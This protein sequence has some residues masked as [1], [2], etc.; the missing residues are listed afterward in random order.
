[1]VY[2]SLIADPPRPGRLT[3]PPVYVSH[4]PYRLRPRIV[5]VAA[6]IALATLTALAVSPAAKAAKSLS[7]AEKIVDDWYGDGRVD[8]IFPISCYRAAIRSLP[9]DVLDYSRAEEDI[10]RAL[11]YAKQ[12]KPDPGP[13]GGAQ[14]NDDDPP[15]GSG[16]PD[17]PGS[18]NE[19]VDTSGPSSL[20]I[21]L[22]VLGALALLLLA[23]GGVGYLNRR[24]QARRDSGPP[25]P[26]GPA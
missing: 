15:P 14:P 19:S 25:G 3:T 23:A 11:Q 13:A 26:P 22:L 7:C 8:R 10:L 24:A 20:P 18:A 12:G 5:F 2:P 21:P 1:M 17:D 16:G 9:V 6:L 4:V